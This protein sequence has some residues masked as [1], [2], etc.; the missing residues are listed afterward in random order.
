MNNPDI[1]NY[2]IAQSSPLQSVLDEVERF[3]YLKVQMP[4][5]ISG[6]LQG[7]ILSMISKIKQP[8]VILEVGTFTGY[9]TICLHSGL[10]ESGKLY[11]IDINSELEEHVK[12]FFEKANVS[13]RTEYIIGNAI[14]V[15]PT[16]SDS[17]DLIFLD[18]DKK[19]YID[20]LNILI[21]KMN[22]GALLITDNVLWKGKVAAAIMDSDTLA[23]H[24]FNIAVLNHPELEVV[25]L[26]IRD[27]I[28]IARKK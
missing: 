15:I 11:T 28:S 10:Q 1:E 9:A 25:I 13:R 5:M 14:S 12:S 17:F 27:G 6:K 8:R 19:K 2:C 16:I 26:P 18:A 22:S 20:Y 21:P 24:N 23:I 4:H 3:T 7:Q